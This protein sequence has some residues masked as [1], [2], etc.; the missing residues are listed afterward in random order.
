[1]VEK[2]DFPSK[3]EQVVRATDNQ[4]SGIFMASKT[5]FSDYYNA[6]N[7]DS[8]WNKYT[9]IIESADNSF[10]KAT[11]SDTLFRNLKAKLVTLDYLKSQNTFKSIVVLKDG[12][13][14]E[15]S[16]ILPYEIAND[17]YANQ[18]YNAIEFTENTV[19]KD[20]F[21]DKKTLIINDLASPID[22]I[23]EEA[24]IALRKE[25]WLKSDL[26]ILIDAL[27]KKY[28]DDTLDYDGTR[29][30][31]LDKMTDFKDIATLNALEKLAVT[32][33]KD[34]FIQRAVL[35]AF[36]N[37]DTLASANR[38][39]DV[40]KGLEKPN[41][42]DYYC[43]NRFM[44]DSIE[45]GKLYF[46]K[47]LTLSTKPFSE[48]VVISISANMSEQDTLHLM[49][50]IFKKYTPQYLTDA[51]DF[52]EK[53]VEFLQHDTIGDD[54]SDAYY[55]LYNYTRFFKN[56]PNTREI[57]QFLRK[58]SNTKHINLL[59]RAIQGLVKNEQPVSGNL[60]QQI[61]ADKST[62]FYLLSDLKRDS[63]L[64]KVPPQYINQ[65]DVAEGIILGDL[66]E[67]DYGKSK[68]FKLIETQKYKGQMLYIFRYKIEYEDE[69]P[70]YIFAVCA[71]PLDKNKYDLA[72][73]L[74]QF[75]EI[76]KETK[77][78]KKI[79]SELLKNHEKSVEAMKGFDKIAPFR[80][81]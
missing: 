81:N 78:Y 74:V 69:E 7:T 79:V 76:T 51:N 9:R 39:F 12:F 5:I 34:T 44:V 54:E 36:L 71:Q 17:A 24:K 43:L 26:S 30:I 14:Y 38:F 37:L 52:L 21:S 67:E 13:Q 59:S 46:E 62:F 50:D 56:A 45:R 60:W 18:F 16:L 58:I 10:V 29:L 27:N 55:L 65:K 57:N 11:I 3:T 68:E 41:L 49:D 61:G 6:V 8:F 31:L 20:I 23:N 33:T 32:T 72:P 47:M 4:T 80:K 70:S 28:A 35:C 75:S 63:L 2:G 1:V 53:N 73:D 66:E 19:K 64:S 40:V 15:F 25:K 42:D 22:S 77:N 48:S